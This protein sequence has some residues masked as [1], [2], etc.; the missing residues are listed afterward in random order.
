M[1]ACIP[2]QEFLLGVRFNLNKPRRN[3]FRYHFGARRDV[4]YKTRFKSRE[5]VAGMFKFV[6]NSG[7]VKLPKF[8]FVEIVGRIDST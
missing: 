5:R 8:W 2:K 1:Q 6:F 3:L 4:L 7:S